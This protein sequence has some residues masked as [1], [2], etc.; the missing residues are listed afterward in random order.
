MAYPERASAARVERSDDIL[1]SRHL[2]PLFCFAALP[3]RL[4][5]NSVKFTRVVATNGILAANP[6]SL[7]EMKR[8]RCS[9][10]HQQSKGALR[11]NVHA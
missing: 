7:F 6:S 4:C 2:I 1:L 8:N 9:V 3:R 5:E 10:Q 11:N